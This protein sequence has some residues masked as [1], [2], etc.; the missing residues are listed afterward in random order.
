MQ[1]LN[2]DVDS[3]RLYYNG[4]EIDVITYGSGTIPAPE[5]NQSLGRFEDGQDEWVIFFSAFARII[6]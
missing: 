6:K 2:F 4:D 3:V 1:R 5:K